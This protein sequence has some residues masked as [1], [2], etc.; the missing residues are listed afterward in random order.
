M[1]VNDVEDGPAV[2]DRELEVHGPP[3]CPYSSFAVHVGSK[4]V[5]RY[6]VPRSAHTNNTVGRLGPLPP[7]FV[8]YRFTAANTVPLE[9]PANRPWVTRSSRHAAA[10][11]GSGIRT[12]SSILA[13]D[14]NG[15]T[16]LDPTPGRWRLRGASPKMTEPLASAAMIR[17]FG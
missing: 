5:S 16:M 2:D 12:T 7:I 6:G 9:P 17:T 8:A 14:S 4:T 1:G 10:V 11:S 15:G 3:R 13:C